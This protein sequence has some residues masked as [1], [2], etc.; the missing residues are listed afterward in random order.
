MAKSSVDSNS[1]AHTYPGEPERVCQCVS[2]FAAFV[3][4]DLENHKISRQPLLIDKAG[5]CLFHSYDESWKAANNFLEKFHE[6]LTLSTLQLKS[7]SDS[8][9]QKNRFD[10]SGF[11]FV[12]SPDATLIDLSGMSFDYKLDLVGSR[13]LHKA[14]FEGSI[15]NETAY[16]ENASFASYAHFVGCKFKKAAYFNSCEFNDF[17]VFRDTGFEGVAS[18]SGSEFPK[19]AAT[20]FERISVGAMLIFKG[21]SRRHAQF[22]NSVTLNLVDSAGRV[23]FENVN[24]K[25]LDGPS[26]AHLR[27]L[28]ASGRAVIGSGC[29][30]YR[31][32]KEIS[33]PYRERHKPLV[34]EI[35]Q[36]FVEFFNLDGLLN[37]TIGVEVEYSEDFAMIRYFSDLDITQSEFE[38]ALSRSV[39]EFLRFLREPEEC[40]KG[41]PVDV[42]RWDVYR[43]IKLAQLGIVPRVLSE[44][45]WSVEDT[46]NVLSVCPG[47]IGV[48]IVINLHEHVANTNIQAGGNVQMVI[49][50]AA[51]GLS[52]AQITQHMGDQFKGIS[53][54]TIVNRSIVG[55]S[56]NTLTPRQSLDL[57]A[58]LSEIRNA[59]SGDAGAEIAS[60]LKEM[61]VQASRE[62]PDKGRIKALWDSAVT[63][64]PQLTTI[65]ES[66]AKVSEL[67]K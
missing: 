50:G 47:P 11:V 63:V 19:A 67:L 51:G 46:L 10:C 56:G 61:E 20:Y 44:R 32:S 43:R 1:C 13:F 57:R 5:L 16:F 18:F 40:L 14:D 30:K 3:T 55:H 64:I 66:V 48:D 8:L 27:K 35:A 53:K 28:E 52:P 21:R 9:T 45:A 23:S 31:V 26:Q 62:N 58:L 54:S 36:A 6:F 49:A 29:D 4:A 24:L 41:L 2:L 60:T 7:R 38:A 33:L 17:V 34:Q 15:F 39:P 42:P 65:A 37:G 25:F 59:L 12:K 22:S